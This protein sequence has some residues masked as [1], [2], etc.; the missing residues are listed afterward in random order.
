MSANDDFEL[1]QRVM[2]RDQQAL[3]ELYRLYGRPVFSM[4]L[5]VLS[6]KTMAEEVT[7]DVFFQVWRWPDRWNPDQGRLINW[8]LTVSRYTAIDHLRREQRRP[9]LT[10]RPLEDMPVSPRLPDDADLRESRQI[11]QS[12]LDQLPDE[13]ASLIELAFFQGLTHDEI[14]QKVG[15]PL[16]TVKSR[17]RLGLGKLKDQWLATLKTPDNTR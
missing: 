8:L 11:L 5:R 1:M 7:Q 3:S 10:A 13:Q 9:T 16:G 2:N 15:L 6:E 4:A 17:I 14:A 12:L